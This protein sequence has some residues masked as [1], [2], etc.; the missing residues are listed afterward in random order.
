M[1]RPSFTFSKKQQPAFQAN[2]FGGSPTMQDNRADRGSPLKSSQ[3]QQAR[4]SSP[5]VPQTKISFKNISVFD[6][7]K[8]LENVQSALNPVQKH[9]VQIQKTV[10]EGALIREFKKYEEFDPENPRKFLIKLQSKVHP[11]KNPHKESVMASAIRDH[12][13]KIVTGLTEILK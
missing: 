12:A 4:S 9:P 13:S 1:Q 2:A 7:S 10:L 6:L 8:E 3:R 5:S 11:D